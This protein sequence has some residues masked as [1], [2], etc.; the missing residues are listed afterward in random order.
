MSL[1][2]ALSVEPVRGRSHD[3]ALAGA[4][5]GWFPTARRDLPWRLASL[6][7]D[8][9]R[10]PYHALVAETM[11]QQTQ[12]SRV[13]EKF[14]AFLLRFPTVASLA[15]ADLDDVLAFWTGLGYYRRARSLHAAA[16]LVVDRFSG[17]VPSASADLRTLP[18]VG[19]Y[20]AGAIASIA[21]DRPD[22]IVDGNVARVLL[23]VHGRA[24]AS[25]DRAVQPWLWERAGSLVRAAASPALFNEGL[26]EL[27]A[28]VCLPPPAMPRCGE[29][30]LAHWCIARRE[31]RQLEIPLP[32]RT[33]KR[34]TIYCAAIVVE[35]AGGGILM[36]Q[37]PARGMW[38][39]LWQV[40]T[41]ESPAAPP[42][43][44]AMARA[45]GVPLRA[46]RD[47]GG[48]EFNATH[49]RLVF[50]VYRA[51]VPKGMKSERGEFVPRARAVGLALSTPQRR[52]LG[53]EG[54]LLS[55]AG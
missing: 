1:S 23:R 12:V 34:S 47:D 11:L 46:V 2:S 53:G 32:K 3:R 33:A 41:I 14:G 21:F 29:C 51:T 30:P 39:G 44:G 22:P 43:K 27:G 45:V 50:S 40:P 5:V 49:R 35:R 6:R 28:T 36:E 9:Q 10:D 31:G 4:I 55:H 24:V 37:R 42:T 15:G 26:M 13:V 16:R 52:I 20:T 48:F 17:R 18:G 25:D 8:E 54:G 7:A 38:A 19:R